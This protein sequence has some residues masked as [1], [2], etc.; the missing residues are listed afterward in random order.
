MQPDPD[1][2]GDIWLVLGRSA[3]PD[4]IVRVL[5]GSRDSRDGPSGKVALYE[6]ATGWVSW[7]APDRTLKLHEPLKLS[8][9]RAVMG[10]HATLA[11]LGYVA[12][13][14]ALTVLSAL[15]AMAILV[16]TRRNDE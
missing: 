12:A 16:L 3:R 5:A 2:P 4:E 10:N 9:L 15:V 8:N 13:I 1:R 7:T 11:P 6:E 14:L